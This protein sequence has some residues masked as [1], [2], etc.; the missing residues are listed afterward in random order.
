MSDK[1]LPRVNDINRPFWML[2]PTVA[3]AWTL[4]GFPNGAT[5]WTFT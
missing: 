3:F 2:S 4:E 1:P 5:R